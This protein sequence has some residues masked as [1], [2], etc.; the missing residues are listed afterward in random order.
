MLQSLEFPCRISSKG[1]KHDINESEGNMFNQIFKE[2]VQGQESCAFA[3]LLS[4][5]KHNRVVQNEKNG[6]KNPTTIMMKTM[7]K[8]NS[9]KEIVKR[10]H[11][12]TQY[13]N[14]AHPKNSSIDCDGVQLTNVR[15]HM[16]PISILW[17]RE[18]W[19]IQLE[20]T[21][22]TKQE[23]IATSHHPVNGAK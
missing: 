4:Y 13:Q 21:F 8:Q 16:V 19:T 15:C 5:R 18:S 1:C 12:D 11:N 14:R 3:E 17:Y 7:M 2:N 9:T 23:R 20:C 6:H 10:A 22:E